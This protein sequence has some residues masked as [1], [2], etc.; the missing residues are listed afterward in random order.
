MFSI[1]QQLHL[2]V[3]LPQLPSSMFATATAQ[4]EISQAVRHGLEEAALAT[5]GESGTSRGWKTILASFVANGSKLGTLLHPELPPM[6]RPMVPLSALHAFGPESE[7]EIKIRKEFESVDVDDA[8]EDHV[9]GNGI[10]TDVPAEP[11]PRSTVPTPAPVASQS[12]TSSHVALSTAR[13]DT[14]ISTTTHR[15]EMTTVMPVAPI[16]AQLTVEDLPSRAAQPSPAS[17]VTL[18]EDFISFSSTS[19]KTSK[20]PGESSK[21]VT[22]QSTIVEESD[23]EEMPELDS[24]SSEEEDDADDE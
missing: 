17:Q 5:E 23:D 1:R 21:V 10:S 7:E 18:T 14:S 16:Q 12:Q 20:H 9:M 15:A 6:H 4:S 19:T 11:L 8:A 22:T 3:I 2:L 13:P 24:G